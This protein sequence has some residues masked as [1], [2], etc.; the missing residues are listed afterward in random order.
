MPEIQQ[1]QHGRRDMSDDRGTNDDASPAVA[2]PAPQARRKAIVALLRASLAITE[3]LELESDRSPAV[4]EL[5]RAIHAIS[6][7]LDALGWEVASTMD[8]AAE[9]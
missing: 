5:S 4:V 2:G 3:A 8:D 9:S 7:A 1:F 6:T